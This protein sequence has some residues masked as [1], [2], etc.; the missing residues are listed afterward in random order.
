MPFIF[1]WLSKLLA[2]LKR[3]RETLAETDKCF[4]WAENHLLQAA[5]E[6][7]ISGKWPR[8]KESNVAPIKRPRGRPRKNQITDN[9]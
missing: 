4:S 1:P 2:S 6:N 3:D 8:K 9:W 5:Y 7:F